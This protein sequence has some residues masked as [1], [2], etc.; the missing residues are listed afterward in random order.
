MGIFD[1]TPTGDAAPTARGAGNRRPWITR[2][3]R[4]SN[5][6]DESGRTGSRDSTG[7]LASWAV[8]PV[9]APRH[10]LGLAPQTV[11][12]AIRLGARRR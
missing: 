4:A 8:A 9:R 11:R 1:Q 12:C 2:R 3:R 6:S 10:P 5:G 7:R